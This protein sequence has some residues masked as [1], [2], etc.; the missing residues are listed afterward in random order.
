MTRWNLSI[1]DETD[2]LVRVFLARTGMK[3]GDL[4]AFVVDACRNE[5]LRRTVE[6]VQAQNAELSPEEAMR[7]ADEAVA[8][9][10][11]TTS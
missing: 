10:R 11:A 6:E 7:L 5:V 4:S 1:P 3:K 8:G 9:I 2:R